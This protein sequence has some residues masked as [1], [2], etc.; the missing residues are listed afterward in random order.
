MTQPRLVATWSILG[1][2]AGP[3]LLAAL[4]ALLMAASW[5]CWP[6]LQLDFGR[7][8]YVAWAL[9]SGRTLYVDVFDKNG[10]LS[11]LLNGLWFKLFGASLTVLAI[12]NL[13]IL[14][15]FLA[16]VYRT[17]Q[18]LTD[19][20]TATLC[21]ATALVVFGIAQEL[22]IGN[23][24]FVTPYNHQ[25]THGLVLGAFG[26]AALERWVE[27]GRA[28]FAAGAGLCIG[29]VFLTKTELFVPIAGASAL[30]WAAIAFGGEA[31]ARVRHALLPFLLA[32]LLPP[33]A[34][35][36]GLAT[37]IPLGVALDGVLGNWRHLGSR[38]LR[39][40]FYRA[41]MGLDHPLENLNAMLCTTLV[42]GVAALAMMGADRVGRDSP[43]SR[44]ISCIVAGTL[45]FAL[46][47]AFAP[48]IPWF[49]APR[50]L[51]I[52]C[53]GCVSGGAWYWLRT[54]ADPLLSR[55]TLALVLWG[56]Y[57][58][59]LLAK[60]GLRPGFSHY[61]FALAAVATILGV[62]LL[63]GAVPRWLRREDG[64]GGDLFRALASAAVLAL[65]F[66]LA[67][68]SN[69]LWSRRTLQLG[70][71][72]DAIKVDPAPLDSRGEIVARGLA[73]LREVVPPGA[74]LA[75][76]PEGAFLNYWL[77][78]P[79][80]TPYLLLT[81][82]EFEAAGGESA[83]LARFQATPPDVIV[84][85]SRDGREFGVGFFGQDPRWGK[86]LVEWA[87]GAYR[88]LETIGANPVGGEGFGL[89]ILRRADETAR[90][91]P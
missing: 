72:S 62:A 87:Q 58:G 80:S 44:R 78:A 81:P 19:R 53:A 43:R 64:H 57:G 26:V 17:C 84:L 70:E 12:C 42:F 1:A 9:A 15:L 88:P 60:L 85:L 61:G 56:S 22:P 39:D 46:L 16:L 40:P 24:N 45:L 4:C 66:V 48:V 36:A 25:Q 51:P 6:D 63:V 3:A 79:N 41:A 91:K 29:L 38:T 76:L 74:T 55:R 5:R 20:F 73:R 34:F 30:A 10:P 7:E 54:R 14:V 69:A 27:S 11:Q 21:A 77:R 75:V 49:S 50:V 52:V 2:L 83:V 68:Q 35:A 90:G 67:Q 23:Y 37:R 31:A 32:A 82:Q 59:L 18:R 8:L 71:G 89:T 13:A 65:L 86:S 33:L 28:R 47:V